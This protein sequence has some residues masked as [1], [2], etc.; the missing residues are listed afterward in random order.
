[1]QIILLYKKV[2]TQHVRSSNKMY[3]VVTRRRTRSKIKLHYALLTI[4]LYKTSMVK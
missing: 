2:K 1:M 4:V 3:V